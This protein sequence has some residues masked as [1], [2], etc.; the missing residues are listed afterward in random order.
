LFADTHK[1]LRLWFEALWHVT[2][3]KY[4]ASA[5]G[6]SASWVWAA[7]YYSVNSPAWQSRNHNFFQKKKKR[8]KNGIEHTWGFE[9]K[10][11]PTSSLA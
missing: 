3:Q 2:N 8:T 7:Y 10:T 1:P 5:L 4:G 9:K 6:C 11:R